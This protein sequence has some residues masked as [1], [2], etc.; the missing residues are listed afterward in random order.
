MS[1]DW[2]NFRISQDGTHHTSQG[3][4]AYPSR[5]LE[6]LK[7]HEPGL[8]PVMDSS[9]AYHI[10]PDGDAAYPERYRRTFGFYEGIAAVQSAE[11]W[12]HILPDGSPLYAE[13]YDWCG[14]FQEGMCPVR[15]SGG[16]YFH[17]TSVGEPAYSARFKY[18]GDYRD[19]FAVAQRNDGRHTHIDGAGKLLHG[20]WFLDLDVFHK[21]LARARDE[22]GWHHVD[23]S[24]LSIY[25][26]RFRSVEPF[27]NGQAR[28]EE[29]DG[30]LAVIDESGDAVAVLR[31]PLRS[32]F[33]DLSEDMV[34]LWKTQTIRA[35]ANLKV[36]DNLPA[37]PE[38]LE[39]RC[40]L[41]SATG[42]RLLRALSEL[43]LVRCDG[44]GFY[45][46]TKKGSH[47]QEHNPE[48]LRAAA[49]MWGAET[50]SAWAQLDES[51]LT[52]QSGFV[53]QHG[54]TF[55]EWA[56]G[57]PDQLAEYH[58]ALAT[59]A[60]HDYAAIAAAM[61]LGPRE[62]ILD[63]GGGTGQFAFALLQANPHLRCTVMDRPEVV[64]LAAP[65]RELAGRCRFASGDFFEEW[66][67]TGE[68][69]LLARVLHDWPDDRAFEILRRAREAMPMGGVLYVVEMLPNDE[70]GYGG[71]LDMNM[72]VMTGGAER[73]LKQYEDLLSRASFDVV[74]VQQTD[75]VS[76][77]I[78]A[79]AV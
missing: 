68:A 38:E 62:N 24:G 9:G 73:T 8:A 50:Y 4:A 44:G 31:E 41:A 76:A 64:A 22:R 29:Y 69:V 61:N 53:R 23:P 21:N 60:R 36:F 43:G 17:I 54:K 56:A 79:L 37:L 28:V 6:V 10:N 70:T 77:V 27:Y 30:S 7:F 20:Q 26:R 71:L 40:G 48:S 51:L 74:E 35:A 1:N 47:L 46:A 11:G 18:A 33:N 34:G 14:N 63:V 75:S 3:R 5:F 16:G 72:L 65:P 59:Y 55:F 67:E 25:E 15:D 39:V 42:G 58:R 19:G 2:R 32:A 49:L 52:G 12:F 45:H 57:R 78:K 66:P 13:R